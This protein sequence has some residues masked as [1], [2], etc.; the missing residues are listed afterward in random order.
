MRGRAVPRGLARRSVM[1]LP[2]ARRPARAAP[3]AAERVPQPGTAKQVA[4]GAAERAAGAIVGMR[5]GGRAGRRSRAF[6]S[7]RKAC[8]HA[9]VQAAVLR[10]PRRGT[11]PGDSV[12]VSFAGKPAAGRRRPVR[13]RIGPARRADEQRP[14]VQPRHTAAPGSSDRVRRRGQA[15]PQALTRRVVHCVTGSRPAGRPLALGCCQGGILTS[16]AKP[17]RRSGARAPCRARACVR[18]RRARSC[19]RA[20][21][22]LQSGEAP[23]SQSRFFLA[24]RGAVQPAADFLACYGMPT[25]LGRRI[26]R[27][28]G[29]WRPRPRPRPALR[30]RLLVAAAAAA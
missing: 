3:G 2:A 18:R 5:R 16:W 24:G 21:K 11:R 1:P 20:K 17:R 23:A 28:G 13:V 7:G 12:T 26:R 8:A 22:F 29:L 14:A 10:V 25:V 19:S 4:G 9:V 15:P 30:R 6:R 27:A